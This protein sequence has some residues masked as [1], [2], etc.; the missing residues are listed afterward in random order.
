MKYKHYKHVLLDLRGV[1]FQSTGISNRIIQWDIISQLNERY[2]HQLNIGEDLFSPFILDYNKM[3][4]QQMSGQLFLEEIW[5]TL[6]FNRELVDFLNSSF[7]VHILSDNYR[8]NI[9]YMTE[10]FSIPSWS[11]SQ[12]YSFENGLTKMDAALF[13]KVLAKLNLMPDEIFLVD[14]SPGKIQTADSC[15]IAGILYLD[16]AQ[17][18]RVLRS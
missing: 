5:N 15:G 14:D 9:E 4:D 1:V 12:F 11:K 7:E 13:E 6:K 2:G 10:R 18:K 16:N 8:E 3:T 17:V